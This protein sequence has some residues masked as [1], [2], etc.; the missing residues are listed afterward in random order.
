VAFLALRDSVGRIKR[1][2]SIQLTIVPDGGMP[3]RLVTLATLA[4]GEQI[5][6]WAAN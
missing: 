1:V 6:I 5:D 3:G 2:D 4:I